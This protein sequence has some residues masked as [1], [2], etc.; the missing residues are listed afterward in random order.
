M[1][2]PVLERLHNELLDPLVSFTFERCLEAGI[3]PPVPDALD[4]VE[5]QV[6][7][8]STLAQAQRAVAVNST[9]RLLGHIGMIVQNTGDPS[10]MDKFD[11]DKSI[12]RYADQLG[13]D[14]DLIVSSDKVALVRQQRAQA[15]AQ[16]QAAEQAK[17]VGSA[18][19]SL[20]TVQTGS[21]PQENAASDILNLFS[22]YNTPSA[23][24]IGVA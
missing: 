4:G 2:G 22:G 21:A 19:Q 3:L 16:Q 18:A 13:V 17:A 6:E 20:G 11:V 14:P 23:T 8:I 24:E 10:A 15:Q 1:L 9:D 7:F 5:L 12:E